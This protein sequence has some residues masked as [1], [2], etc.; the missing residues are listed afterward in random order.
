MNRALL[1]G[2]V[3][4]VPEELEDCQR[5]I[6]LVIK[7]ALEQKVEKVVFMG[8]QTNF[9]RILHVEVMA[10]WRKSF[11]SMKKAGLEVYALVGN[12]DFA[13][14]GLDIHS[15]MAHEEQIEVVDA[16]VILFDGVMMVPYVSGPENFVKLVNTFH[17]RQTILCHQTFEGAQ[18]DNGFYAS[19]GVDM[20]LVPC[21][22]LISGHIHKNAELG[23]LTYVGA[24]RWRSL[25]DADIDRAI[26]IYSF[27]DEGNVVGKEAFSTGEVCRQIK[28]RLDTPESP[29]TEE[30]GSGNDWRVDIKGPADWIERRKAELAGP[31]VRIRTFNTTKATPRLRES[32]GIEKSFVAFSSKYTPKYGTRREKLAEMATERLGV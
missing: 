32:E 8:D 5:L 25:S 4:A 23:K 7:T 1:V 24:P 27:D 18:Y 31:G 16:P 26:W 29:V 3:H 2:D 9:H 13:G 14:E 11:A 22:Y 6:D 12:H 15:M 19:D 28:Y 20:N 30:L 10:F 17:P 21:K